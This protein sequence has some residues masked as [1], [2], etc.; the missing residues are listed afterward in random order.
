M[1]EV[2]TETNY[3]KIFTFLWS[4]ATISHQIY[5]GVVFHSFLDL[6][7]TL[8]AII[9]LFKPNYYRLFLSLLF[10]QTFTIFI[11][12]PR[13]FNHWFL[14]FFIAA[15][16]ILNYL[17]L[18]LSKMTLDV[19][20]KNL[21]TNF[22]PALRIILIIVYF[23]AFFHKLNSDYF[24]P[25]VSCGVFM[26]LKLV[27][28]YGFLP[29]NE[30]VM[31]FFIYLSLL[32]EVSIPILLIFER[33]RILGILT[34]LLTHLVFGILG[35]LNFSIIMFALLSLYL[36]IDFFTY[37]NFS[38]LEPKKLVA[39]NFKL[40]KTVAY[41]FTLIFICLY[42]YNKSFYIFNNKQILINIWRVVFS[43]FSLIL[44]LF[45]ILKLRIGNYKWPNKFF[46]INFLNAIIIFVFLLNCLSP[47]LGFKTQNVLSMYSNLRT[48]N[49][50]SNHFISDIIMIGSYQKDI[51]EIKDSNIKK[52]KKIKTIPYVQL[53][54]Y[55]FEALRKNKKDVF[56]E[57]IKDGVLINYEVESEN[58]IKNQFIPKL[59]KWKFFD[60][61]PVTVSDKQSCGL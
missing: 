51:V 50:R 46:K 35:Y 2:K 39:R 7:L 17:N 11:Y 49:N 24:S 16:I 48:E 34:G 25:D 47:Y 21:Y 6:L 57:Y 9:T 58:F 3:L 31:Y 32:I 52:L 38:S 5:Y 20:K 59:F 37:K 28:I 1:T 45:F 8:L 26:Y 22:A 43:L 14:A 61:K 12:L 13:A 33:T 53:E 40:F 44:I 56:V 42:I 41:I 55:M 29:L 10:I 36:P 54:N 23:M 60:F 18:V 15:A 4:A 19:D 30:P 27:D